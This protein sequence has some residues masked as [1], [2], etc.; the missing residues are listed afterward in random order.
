MTYFYSSSQNV[1]IGAS[2]AEE[3]IGGIAKKE[4]CETKYVTV[5]IPGAVCEEEGQKYAAVRGL[6]TVEQGNR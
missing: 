2:Q 3:A 4:V 6:P 5:G 1:P